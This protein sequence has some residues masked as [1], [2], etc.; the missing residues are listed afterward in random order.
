MY[1]TKNKQG[2]MLQK[3]KA[4]SVQCGVQQLQILDPGRSYK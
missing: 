2:D 1:S 3:K 4:G